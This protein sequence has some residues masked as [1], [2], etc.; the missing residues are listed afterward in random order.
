MKQIIINLL[1]K[2]LWCL[3]DDASMTCK[4]MEEY[5]DVPEEFNEVMFFNHEF[6]FYCKDD[7][8]EKELRK[9]ALEWLEMED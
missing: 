9:K 8:K 5:Y 3:A 6:H 7:K 1:L 4:N 2:L